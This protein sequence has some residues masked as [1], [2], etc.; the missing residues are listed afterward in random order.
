MRRILVVDDDEATRELVKARLK[1]TYN[2]VCTAD[3]TEALS[4]ALRLQPQCIL[5]DLLMPTLTGFEL[6]KTLSSLS[7]TRK[8]PILVVSGN[9][10]SEY[11]D[12]C[13]HLGAKDYFQKPIDFARLR[14]RIAELVDWN[15]VEQ[16]RELRINLQVPIELRG[17]NQYGKAFHEVTSTE[18]VSVTGFRCA[19][20]ISLRPKMLV[21]VY[22]RAGN[23]KLRVGRAHVV[24][25]LQPGSGAP[26]YGFHFTQKPVEW[27]L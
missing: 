2:I 16:R 9:P 3:P 11:R 25:Q 4:L 23:A 15:L 21:E 5:L 24:H 14:V 26:Q 7:L 20:T 13:S 22:L 27:L 8:T 1:D 18:N 17:L 10:A 19:C 12:F 6:C